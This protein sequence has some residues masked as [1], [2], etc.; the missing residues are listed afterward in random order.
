MSSPFDL[1][2]ADLEVVEQEQEEQ[3]TSA[4]TSVGRRAT[5]G[6]SPERSR[7]RASQRP[8]RRVFKTYGLAYLLTYISFAV[9]SFS[10]CY[11]LVSAGNNLGRSHNPR[12]GGGPGAPGGSVIAALVMAPR[13][14]P[15]AP[16][17]RSYR[18]VKHFR[19]GP[20][21]QFLLFPSSSSS[22]RLEPSQA[23]DLRFD[24]VPRTSPVFGSPPIQQRP[25]LASAKSP[26]R[27][28]RSAMAAARP[29]AAAAG[30][31]GG[32]RL[33]G[34]WPLRP[35]SRPPRS[36][37]PAPGSPCGTLFP[38]PRAGPRRAGGGTRSGG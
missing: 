20:S 38:P 19:P 24:G 11:A 36:L 13:G 2:V 28:A 8:L 32:V 10:L 18:T 5:G 27:N 34:G 9:V 7:R 35:F 23:Q 29:A 16:D 6:G 1:E 22:R 37:S 33:I 25:R 14:P 31:R 30:A 12:R 17:R 26:R 15:P 4:R 3:A 21:S